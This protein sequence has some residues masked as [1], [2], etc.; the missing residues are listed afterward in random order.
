MRGV[1]KIGNRWRAYV[2]IYGRELQ[3]Y[4]ETE[5]EAIEKV[6]QYRLI[7]KAGRRETW[8][9]RS[10]KRDCNHPDLPIGFMQS[11]FTKRGK[12]GAV[13]HYDYIKCNF[14]LNGKFKDVMRC[15][16]VKITREEAIESVKKE[17]M[18]LLKTENTNQGSF[19]HGKR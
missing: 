13:Y 15:F 14:K 7:K 18:E 2:T 1:T 16:G 9:K 12:N 3:L 4:F 10:K 17:V 6:E 19:K 11:H 8:A 5:N